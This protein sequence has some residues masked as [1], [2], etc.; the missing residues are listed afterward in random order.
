[1]EKNLKLRHK[2]A[3]LVREYL[4]K[5]GFMEIE[6]PM[7]TKTSPEGAR[8]FLVP[9]R[10]QPGKF[11]ALPQA[12]QQYKQLLMIAGFEKY[13]QIA[14]AMRD[15]DL[16]G[17]RQLEHTQI[18][19]EMSFVQ[20]RDVQLLCRAAVL[21]ADQRLLRGPRL[22]RRLRELHPRVRALAR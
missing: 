16:R 8:D 15:E 2:A 5:A 17:D 13:Y 21:R 20:E 9:S 22:R 18:D 3:T 14:R 11:Y 7:L 10:M 1:M 6:T 4:N 12:P 19:L